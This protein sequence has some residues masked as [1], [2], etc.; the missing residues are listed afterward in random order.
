MS[1]TTSVV[2]SGPSGI[3]D[4]S[5]VWEM[6]DHTPFHKVDILQVPSTQ[7]CH[8]DQ[9]NIT[10]KITDESLIIE[11][12]VVLEPMTQCYRYALVNQAFNPIVP[13][14][15]QAPSA[16]STIDLAPLDAPVRSM[17]SG[18]IDSSGN[19]DVGNLR[20]VTAP[21]ILPNPSSQDDEHSEDHKHASGNYDS[22]GEC[23]GRFCVNGIWHDL[24]P[25]LVPSPAKS[26]TALP[27][28]AVGL[29]VSLPERTPTRSVKVNKEDHRDSDGYIDDDVVVYSDYSDDSDHDNGDDNRFR[30][31]RNNYDSDGAIDQEFGDYDSEGEPRGCSCGCGCHFGYCHDDFTTNSSRARTKMEKAKNDHDIQ[32][33][34]DL[35]NI[36]HVLALLKESRDQVATLNNRVSSLKSENEDLKAHVTAT[37]QEIR[38]F[39]RSTVTSVI[40]FGKKTHELEVT[41][42]VLDD[43]LDLYY[44]I[45]QNLVV[46]F[47]QHFE[48]TEKSEPSLEIVKA[49]RLPRVIELF[50]NGGWMSKEQ[51]LDLGRQL[52]QY[53]NDS[54]TRKKI[55]I[56]VPSMGGNV[57]HHALHYT[58]KD[59]PNLVNVCIKWLHNNHKL[60]TWPY[61]AR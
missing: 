31:D 3:T 11:Q 38:D 29:S 49:V 35:E 39:V 37:N 52:A 58:R 13:N 27:T 61:H 41:Q 1:S 15:D 40:D 50:T 4:Q 20:T 12:Q 18:F 7:S 5:P 47:G 9:S 44:N 14:D 23:R 26:A 16:A 10:T 19:C 60:L 8:L 51:K 25:V 30:N 55:R 43:H 53:L 45:I 57:T 46:E 56:T 22:N 32:T 54:A 2:S 24:A 36:E 28:A 17:M 33:R 59:L 6:I 48:T 21:A 34:Q 42:K